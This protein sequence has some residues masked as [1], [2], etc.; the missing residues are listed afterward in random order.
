VLC[1]NT[2]DTPEEA[3][4][5]LKELVYVAFERYEEKGQALPPLPPDYTSRATHRNLTLEVRTL[6]LGTPKR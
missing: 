2:G 6:S 5:E 3:I 4:K 1:S